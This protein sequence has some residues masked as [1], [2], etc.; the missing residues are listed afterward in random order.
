VSGKHCDNASVGVL[1]ERD[2]RW[3][4]FERATPPVG[5]AP[6]AGHV[7]DEHESYVDA[8]RAE[9]REE[10]GLT[11]DTWELT[12]AGGWRNNQCRRRP[13]PLGTGHQWQV[14]NATV[15]GK[16][17]PSRREARDPRWLDRAELQRLA[18]R[19]A[20][21]ARGDTTALSFTAS[22]GIEPVWAGFLTELRLIHLSSMELSAIE[23]VMS[24]AT[25]GRR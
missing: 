14:F 20:A 22:P 15:S 25:T 21:Y 13:G 6:V 16:L 9:V 11:V 3:L 17:R 2:G 5:I 1:I 8:A 24:G 12:R 23:A 7:F 10:L 4:M 19:T 18:E